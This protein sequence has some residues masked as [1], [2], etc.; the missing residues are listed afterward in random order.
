VSGVDR[1]LVEK[2]LADDEIES[3]PLWKPMH[4][5]PVF[6]DADHV[7]TGVSE[8]LFD[9]GMCLPSGSSLSSDDQARV[10]GIIREL[11]PR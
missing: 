3:R 11:W 2:R 4:L 9:R 6:E 1:F 8:R 7:V 10:I 5:Q